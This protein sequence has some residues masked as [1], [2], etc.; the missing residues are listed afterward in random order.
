MVAYVVFI[1]WHSLLGR[2]KQ[3]LFKKHA[4]LFYTP[5]TPGQR[6][7]ALARSLDFFGAVDYTAEEKSGPTIRLSLNGEP[8]EGMAFWTLFIS[9]VPLILLALPFLIVLNRNS[10]FQTN[11]KTTLPPVSSRPVTQAGVLLLIANSFCGFALIDSW[12]FAVY[13]TFASI[14]KPQAPSMILIATDAKEHPLAQT[15]PM[16]N[17][18]FTSSFGS[19]ARL[20]AYL[21]LLLSQDPK[22]NIDRFK[23]LWLLWQQTDENLEGAVAVNF[24]RAMF[25]TIP[26]DQY[27]VYRNRRLLF[28]L[29]VGDG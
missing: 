7:A 29:A 8:A 15:V 22:Q 9:R 10:S 17:D 14:D 24:H 19:P 20:R 11:T 26:E 3:H 23:A 12:P 4:I 16:K 5:D 25:S 18:H 2:S 1:D 6:W 13:P 28:S 21:N 27:R